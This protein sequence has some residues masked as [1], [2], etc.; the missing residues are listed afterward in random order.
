[1][2]EF[3]TMPSPEIR[4]L[5]TREDLFEA[6]AAEFAAQ[7]T[8]AVRARGRFTVALS[9]GST[10]KGLYS[11]LATRPGI[12]WDK[13]YFFWGDERH[14]PPDHPDSNYRMANEA[15]LSR[16]PAPPDHVFRVRAEE[17]DADAA[18]LQYEQTLKDVFHLSA[19]EF[20]RFDLILLGLGP[21][22][23]AASLFPDSAALNE[24]R[25]LVVANWVEK[26]KT[27]R[28]TFTFPVI[29]AAACVIFLASGPDKAAI[30]HEV[31]ENKAANLPSQKVQPTNGR[32]LW[33]IDDA[34][35]SALSHKP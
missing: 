1:V 24:T 19:G 20:P 35:A 18:A 6:A 16:I 27:D 25:R 31:L 3:T 5:K 2:S 28:L 32:L 8:A 22:G 21:D 17:K 15:L 9:G 7:A 26:F 29:N 14:V 33:L 30:L 13:I 4:I 34:A 11:L 23:H 10:P 12:P